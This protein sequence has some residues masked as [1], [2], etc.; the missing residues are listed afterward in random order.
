MSGSSASRAAT[1]EIGEL[2]EAESD[3]AVALWEEGGLI[4]PWND[5][6]ADIRLA[7]AGPSSTVIAARAGARLA[8]TVMVGW[9]GHRGWIYYLAVARDFRRR[10]I[11]G[12]MVRAAED[13]L[14][15]R[16][17]PKLNLLVRA[18]NDAVLG[19]YESLGYRRS[20][21]ILLQRVLR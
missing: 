18:E 15:A 5:P 20:D 9:D 7:L 4:R 17:A 10:G 12:R 6:R 19:F 14:V 11:G 1:I 21:A 3:A 8:A 16:D 13:W 2:S